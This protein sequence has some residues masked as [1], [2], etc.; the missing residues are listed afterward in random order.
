MRAF[1]F[2]PQGQPIPRPDTFDHQENARIP[3]NSQERK[4]L[5]ALAPQGPAAVFRW[6]YGP[7]SKSAKWLEC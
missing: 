3:A 2:A 6:L 1:G 7:Q 4:E 5:E